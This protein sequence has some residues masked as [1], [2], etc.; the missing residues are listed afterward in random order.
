MDWLPRAIAVV[1]YESARVESSDLSRQCRDNLESLFERIL[2]YEAEHGALPTAAFYGH[3]PEARCPALGDVLDV[4]QR[5]TLQ[6]PAASRDLRS[7]GWSSYL[8]NRTLNGKRTTEIAN[9]SETWMMM[10]MIGP[11]AWLIAN[12]HA[13]HHGGVNVLFADG[14]VRWMEGFSWNEWGRWGTR[15]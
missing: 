8:W 14:S 7:L 15:R 9:P 13:G 10:D 11:H 12:R 5:E 4:E 1:P 3:H 6:C 2:A